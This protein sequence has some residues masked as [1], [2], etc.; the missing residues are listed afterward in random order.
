[1]AEPFSEKGSAAFERRISRKFTQKTT[2]YP[3]T[4]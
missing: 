4:S 2:G 1:M 3:Y